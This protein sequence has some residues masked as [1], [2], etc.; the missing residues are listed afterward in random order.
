MFCTATGSC[1]GYVF[2]T[3]IKFWAPEKVFGQVDAKTAKSGCCGSEPGFIWEGATEGQTR[4]DLGRY[5]FAGP[6]LK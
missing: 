5:C 1:M 3:T 6:S 2:E 4:V